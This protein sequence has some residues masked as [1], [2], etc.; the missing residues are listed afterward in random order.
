MMNGGYMF[1]LRFGEC[2]EEIY[3]PPLSLGEFCGKNIDCFTPKEDIKHPKKSTWFSGETRAGDYKTGVVYQNL[4]SIHNK[5]VIKGFK[6]QLTVYFPKYCNHSLWKQTQRDEFPCKAIAQCATGDD[7]D[8]LQDL[9]EF[10]PIS[11]WYSYFGM[12][13]YC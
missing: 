5:G 1:P 9:N 10:G 8:K 2:F 6:T 13:R 4:L 7:F 3:G 11:L 12:M